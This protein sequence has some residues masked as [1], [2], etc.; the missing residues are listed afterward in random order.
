MALKEFFFYSFVLLIA[1]V[2][3]FHKVVIGNHGVCAACQE[4]DHG[5]S[6]TFTDEDSIGHKTPIGT[7]YRLVNL[8]STLNCGGVF[9]RI[10]P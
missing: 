2:Q 7:C 10:V 6:R 3:V 5:R 1:K 4:D 8:K 9:L